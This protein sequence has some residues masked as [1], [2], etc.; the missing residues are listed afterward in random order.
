LS[1]LE[2]NKPLL[3]VSIGYLREN[4]KIPQT[5]ITRAII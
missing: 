4:T 2:S 5:E 1:H 3:T